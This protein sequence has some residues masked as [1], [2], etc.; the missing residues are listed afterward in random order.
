[1][2]LKTTPTL[3]P[4]STSTRSPSPVR[5]PSDAHNV[6][7]APRDAGIEADGDLNLDL[8]HGGRASDRRPEEA[9]KRAILRAN[10][11]SSS[12]CERT[13][14]FAEEGRAASACKY[15]DSAQN[16]VAQ[17]IAGVDAGGGVGPD[18][19]PSDLRPQASGSSEHQIPSII[20]ALVTGHRAPRTLPANAD[21]TLL[22]FRRQGDARRPKRQVAVRARTTPGASRATSVWQA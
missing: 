18:R 16:R 15:R 13:K 11:A 1:M 22:L 12:A 8:D 17:P 4:S 6:L 10:L 5:K 21:C 19:G 3:A 20:S 14:L 2:E 9:R 7:Q